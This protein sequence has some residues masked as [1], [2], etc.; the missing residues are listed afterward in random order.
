[1]T[2]QGAGSSQES[3]NQQAKSQDQ[4]LIK[5]GHINPERLDETVEIIEPPTKLYA[6]LSIC[7]IVGLIGWSVFAKIPQTVN[8][9][10]IF[11]EPNSISLLKSSGEGTVL[12][13]RE[14]KPETSHKIDSLISSA[15][16][17]I[18]RYISQGAVNTEERANELEG[19]VQNIYQYIQ[20]CDKAI[21]G[22]SLL[23]NRVVS[24]DSSNLRG[25]LESFV[26]GEVIAYVLNKEGASKVANQ[27]DAYMAQRE[28]SNQMISSYQS[29]W[30]QNNQLKL[31]LGTRVKTLQMLSQKGVVARSQVLDAEKDYLSQLNSLSNQRIDLSKSQEQSTKGLVDLLSTIYSDSEDIQ[32]RANTDSYMVSRLVRSG[33]NVEA[34]DS[35]ALL[36][37]NVGSGKQVNT[38]L[39]FAP[40]ESVKGLK[41]GQSVRV[42]PVNVSEDQYGSITGRITQVSKLA[43]GKSSASLLLGMDTLGDEIYEKN[44]NMFMLSVALDKGSNMSGYKWT[45]SNGPSYKVP[46]TTKAKVTITYREIRPIELLLPMIRMATQ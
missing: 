16:S 20:I 28:N 42:S 6:L 44:D 12:F 17:I 23:V 35:V 18:L 25:G 43:L 30:N 40:L 13:T 9:S 1:M 41:P 29:L 3:G 21:S 32:L 2:N 37:R 4:V 36:A 19:L 39:A 46:I 26:S 27:L 15:E 38:I 22:S 8:A 34:N 11:V 5:R 14:I 24:N 10:G 45:A 31:S 33:Q 7:G